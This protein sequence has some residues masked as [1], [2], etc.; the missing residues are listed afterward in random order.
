VSFR[1]GTAL[2]PTMLKTEDG[3]CKS[4]DEERIGSMREPWPSAER[5][6]DAAAEVFET[7][8]SPY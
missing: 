5:V 3:S 4:E 6:F 1:I 2:I 7:V 8:K